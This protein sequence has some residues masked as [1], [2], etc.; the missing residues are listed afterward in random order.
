MSLGHQQSGTI[1][2]KT[3]QRWNGVAWIDTPLNEFP[4]GTGYIRIIEVNTPILNLDSLT[5]PIELRREM[6]VLPG[7]KRE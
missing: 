2:M 5:Q 4:L 6:V 7:G 3:L 1:K